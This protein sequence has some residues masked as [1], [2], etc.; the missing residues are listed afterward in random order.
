MGAF[1]NYIK[2]GGGKTATASGGGT[3]NSYVKKYRGVDLSS[4]D[5]EDEERSK[6][7][8]GE[9]KRKKILN[10]FLDKGYSWEDISKKTGVDLN[11]IKS[12]SE[13]T[14]PDYGIT[15]Q[16]SNFQKAGDVASSVG[17][18]LL[19][20][21]RSVSEGISGAV[22]AD[23]RLAGQEEALSIQRQ[24]FESFTKAYRDKKITKER[25]GKLLKSLDNPEIQQEIDSVLKE[26]NPKRV[27]A[28]AAEIATYGFGG[29]SLR[30]AAKARGAAGVLRAGAATAASGGIGGGSAVIQNDPEAS[31][32]DVVEGAAMG[33]GL[34][35]G[36]SGLA[37]GIGSKVRGMRSSRI[38]SISDDVIT[39]NARLLPG[40][41]GLPD[42][43]L[44][45]AQII[46]KV[47]PKMAVISG[48][49]I[50]DIKQLELVEKK[51]R[52]AQRTSNITPLEARSLVKQRQELLTRIQDPQTPIAQEIRTLDN[53]I[54]EA[55]EMGSKRKVVQLTQG[56]DFLQ[57]QAVRDAA[58][59]ESEAVLLGRP[60]VSEMT[61]DGL[62]E[63]PNLS[64]TSRMSGS[65]T[66][67]SSAASKTEAKAIKESLTEGF[68]G[69]PTYSTMNLDEQAAKVVDYMD[70]DYEAAKQIALGKA[71]APDGVQAS[72]FYK[73]VESRA[74]REGD[75]E[76]M[77]RLATESTVPK[78]A[79]SFGQ[80]NAALAYKDPE[81][82]VTAFRS[83]AEARGASSLNIPRTIS[84]EESGKVVSLAQDV[85][86]AKEAIENGGDRLA[87][88][89]A[90]VAYDDYVQGLI[91]Q[92]NKKTLK[93]TLKSPVEAITNVA[94]VTKSLRASL[95]N[96][97]LLR[98]GWKTLFTH[99]GTWAKNSLKSFQ[100]FA[101]TVGGKE[102]VDEVR[103]DIVSRP[104]SLN[105]LYKKMGVDVFGIKEEAFPSSLPEKIPVAGRFF[106]ASDAAYTGFQQ[107]TRADLADK[108]L[109][110]AQKSGVDLTS[111]KELQSIGKLVNS[112]TSRGGLG[113]TGERAS[114][115]L[116]NV[117]FSPR[118]LK[119]NIDVLT[120][121]AF[122]K[123]VTPFV[124]K[125][126]ARNLLQ[127]ALGSAA[128]LKLASEVTGGKGEWDPRSSNFGK[129]RV[130]DTR[131]DLSGGMSSIVTLGARLATS[132]SK[133]STTGEVK[134]L[135]SG[136]FGSS[137]T[138]DT[139]YNFFENK[140]SPAASVIRDYLKGKD[141]DGN[142]PTLAST[143][144]NLTMPLI[145]DNFL[146]L[147]NNPRAADILPTMI[148][149]SL[150]ISVNTYG[151]D[152]NWNASNAQRVK[153]F[154]EKVGGG[155]FEE[156][157]KKFNADFNGWY[158]KVS[159]DDRF[160]KL[161]IE[162]REKIVTSK[163][164][165]LTEDIM[166][167]YGYRYKTPSRKTSS[168]SL[169]DELKRY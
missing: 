28:G 73:G 127:I 35:L 155:K 7:S 106:K 109:E 119:S 112:L 167:G 128:A 94:G 90:R 111:K 89:K 60:S 105:G 97:A 165:A 151:L 40:A 20:P 19:Q 12:F 34:G 5:K 15:P 108:Y 6:R 131:F 50:N 135:N 4:Y 133:S 37:S 16:K 83:I 70:A 110:I 150:G 52:T 168:N 101:R 148:A 81:S 11:T 8:K 24:A 26:T 27:L 76:L 103:A 79:T 104:N 53:A 55:E 58:S 96:S 157:N 36:V 44:P 51:I 74:V 10:S 129:I 145:I 122:Q 143:A 146:E 93:E 125:R 118:L 69:L 158:D 166:G 159:D 99:P 48:A 25:Y 117:F 46:T 77:E 62:P 17:Q 47:D 61:L 9:D 144:K 130:K 67:V 153:G 102:V 136:E 154:K 123:G 124:R 88:G 126:A 115:A 56:R 140:T 163:R 64:A 141:F 33:A 142:K 80:F 2:G 86:K 71:P 66:K 85:A 1:D 78:T 132:S 43:A 68:D 29:G 149:E 30:A 75:V 156:A 107:R 14:R 59:K 39:D 121:H 84:P 41:S 169:I 91:A 31:G 57:D 65:G 134:K 138:L 114:K 49:D 100:D 18:G 63:Q 87:Y 21:F 82:P 3:F 42:D 38:P 164:N 161:P 120:A 147:K 13:E 162:Q 23:D 54:S 95:D 137:S 45:S 160:W 152:S 32:L 113:K 72:S 92:A 116:N 22:T 98:Q 139:V